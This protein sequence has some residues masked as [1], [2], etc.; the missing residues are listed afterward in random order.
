MKKNALNYLAWTF[1]ASG[2]SAA[3]E[4]PNP[5]IRNLGVKEKEIKK[6]GEEIVKFP[7]VNLNSVQRQL[8]FSSLH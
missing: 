2:R 7:L 5:P 8:A 4:M 6:F 1:A 3:N